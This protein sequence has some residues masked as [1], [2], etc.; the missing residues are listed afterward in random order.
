[1]AKDPIQLA[2]SHLFKALIQNPAEAEHLL[3]ANPGDFESDAAEV[4]AALH[5]LN[6]ALHDI[7]QELIDSADLDEARRV[8]LTMDQVAAV[9][10]GINRAVVKFL[11][12]AP[13]VAAA[14]AQLQGAVGDLDQTEADVRADTGNLGEVTAVLTQLTRLVNL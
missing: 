8:K 10:I 3:G 1:M 5:A 7:F 13:D 2:S 9:L 4:V 11:D 12:S 6:D 14:Q